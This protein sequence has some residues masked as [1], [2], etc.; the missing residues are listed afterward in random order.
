MSNW[1]QTE[2]N[3]INRERE[4]E[5][6]SDDDDDDDDDLPPF[7]EIFKPQATL[8]LSNRGWKRKIT[9][10]SVSNRAR[11]PARKRNCDRASSLATNTEHCALCPKILGESDGRMFVLT[12]C[13]CVCNATQSRSV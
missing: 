1:Q 6:D 2:N 10:I 4:R 13:G 5:R 7:E 3:Q 9:S 8:A 12:L 11:S